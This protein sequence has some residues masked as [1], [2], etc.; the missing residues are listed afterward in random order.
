VQ[1]PSSPQLPRPLSTTDHVPAQE[2][3]PG[4]RPVAHSRNS[5]NRQQKQPNTDHFPA[6]RRHLVR[7]PWLTQETPRADNSNT[8]KTDHL[9]AQEP[10]PGQR[11]VAHSRNSTSRQLSPRI[12]T[13]FPHNAGTWSAARCSLKKLHEPTTEKNRILTIFP[14][15]AGTWSAILTTFPHKSR[16]LVRGTWLTQETPRVDPRNKD[17][18]PSSRTTAGIWSV[19]VDYSR[20]VTSQQGILKTLPGEYSRKSLRQKQ[21]TKQPVPSIR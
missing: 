21:K 13:T 5:T 6:Q 12:L 7:S 17:N 10:A 9:P 15:N 8:E 2:P 16:H 14:H 1:T 11:H 3:A 20:N 4:Q 18:G 19:L